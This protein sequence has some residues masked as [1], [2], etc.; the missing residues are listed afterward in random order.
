MRE[1]E[2]SFR[3]NTDY[4]RSQTEIRPH[5]RPVLID[6]LIEVHDRFRLLPE[7]LFITINI[8]DQ[9]LGRRNVAMS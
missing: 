4:M 1:S 9:F 5:M 8:I 3:I 6:W 7:T 2:T